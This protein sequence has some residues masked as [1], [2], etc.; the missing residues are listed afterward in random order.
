MGERLFPDIKFHAFQIV[1]EALLKRGAFHP[2]IAKHALTILA[3]YSREGGEVEA[4]REAQKLLDHQ[5]E[6]VRNSNEWHQYVARI[7]RQVDLI[8]GFYDDNIYDS[9]L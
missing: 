3:V 6:H 8:S 7:K 1:R 2:E 9:P 5:G 4:V